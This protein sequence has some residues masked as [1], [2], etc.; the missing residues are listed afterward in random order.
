MF[1]LSFS[2]VSRQSTQLAEKYIQLSNAAIVNSSKWTCH[3]TLAHLFV[4][5]EI[6]AVS[7]ERARAA[8]VSGWF[9]VSVDGYLLRLHHKGC[10]IECSCE[11][12]PLPPYC[13]V[14]F[15]WSVFTARCPLSCSWIAVV[16]SG[17]ATGATASLISDKVNQ[18]NWL[19]CGRG[20]AWLDVWFDCAGCI[21][22]RMLAVM[23]CSC[24]V[25][26]FGV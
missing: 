11:R 24:L 20:F 21:H 18:V 1:V 12:F 14:F 26:Q 23:T 3:I 2:P 19:F 5:P 17:T 22:P 8:A 10:K 6:I 16:S 25:A 9:I 13:I 4:Y 7:K 15:L